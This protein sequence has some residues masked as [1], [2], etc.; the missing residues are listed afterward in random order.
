MDTGG[1]GSHLTEEGGL[2][3]CVILGDSRGSCKVPTGPKDSSISRDRGKTAGVGGVWRGHGEG[4]FGRHQS[5]S[6]KP[7]EPQ[8]EEEQCGFRRGRG[9]TDQLFTLARI[10]EGAWEYAYSDY[11]CF[12]DLEKVYDRV[13]REIL[14]E[15]LWGYRVRGSLLGAN[16]SIYSQ[17]ESCVLVPSGGWLPPGLRLVTIPVCDIH[18]QDFKAQLWRREVA[19]WWAEDCI[20]AFA[21]N[22]VLMAPS[23]CHLQHSL[24]QFAAECEVV[25]M[26]ISTLKAMVLSRK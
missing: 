4:L 12:V 23:A 26:R 19:V 11:M 15:V 10:L 9:T 16:Q 21:D 8:I 24:D 22:V 20:A 13:P 25:G 2:P 14:W 18:G 6:G 3:G 1:Q 5:V 7:F 17:S